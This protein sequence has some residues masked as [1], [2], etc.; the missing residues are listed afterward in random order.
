M[1]AR[2]RKHIQTSKCR[3]FVH[4]VFEIKHSIMN[5]GEQ[6]RAPFC[7]DGSNAAANTCYE[8]PRISNGVNPV[9]NVNHWEAIRRV[10]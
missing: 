8:Y 2:R 9:G 5:R 6:L 10:L 7:V 4:F 3:G 1:K